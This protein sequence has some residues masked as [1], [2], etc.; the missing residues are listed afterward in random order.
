MAAALDQTREHATQPATSSAQSTEA[1]R[2]ERDE[3]AEVRLPAASPSL[4]HPYARRAS[5]PALRTRSQAVRARNDEVRTQMDMMRQ[6]L[7]D[8]Q[9]MQGVEGSATDGATE[10]AR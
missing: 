6:L 7:A 8:M 4:P 2:R 3:L 9:I 10:G 5:H 1:L